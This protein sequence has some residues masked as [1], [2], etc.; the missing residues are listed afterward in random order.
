MRAKDN[1]DYFNRSSACRPDSPRAFLERLGY[2]D[3]LCLRWSSGRAC[4][5]KRGASRSTKGCG[6]PGSPYRGSRLAPRSTSF[7]TPWA[8]RFPA[9]TGCYVHVSET[10]EP[11]RVEVFSELGE[12]QIEGA[13]IA[14]YLYSRYCPATVSLPAWTSRINITPATKKVTYQPERE[15]GADELSESRR[16]SPLDD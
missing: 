12:T 16:G 15:R 14:A 4:G 8:D 6:R 3:T 7:I 11:I 13:A 2:T 9:V 1:Q 10:T 5:A